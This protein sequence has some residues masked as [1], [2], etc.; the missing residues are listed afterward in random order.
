MS[1][2]TY[3]MPTMFTMKSSDPRWAHARKGV[4]RAFSGT[5]IRH[6]LLRGQEQ[7]SSTLDRMAESGESFDP[8]TL[9]TE[10]ALG[11]LGQSM[12]GGFDFGL[13]ASATPSAGAA[14]EDCVQPSLGQEFMDNL[15]KTLP[16]YAYRQ[17]NDPLRKHML[18]LLPRALGVRWFPLAAEA[19][20]AA[21]RNMQ[22]SQQVLDAFR[23]QREQATPDDRVTLD[24]T[25]L[26]H[27]V[28]NQA[29]ESDEMRA[30]DVTTFIVAGH[31][32][33]GFTIAWLLCELARYP[34]RAH[35]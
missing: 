24:E 3:G 1:G 30:A 26:G 9:M 8:A 2:A 12:L 5:Y 23:L 34:E 35:V 13:H 27:L 18:R 21:R 11:M 16:E 29:Y 20:R 7:L 6:A 19:D 32:T 28:A 4:A 25:I 17:P 10:L 15:H 31:D 33:T 22:I 14:P